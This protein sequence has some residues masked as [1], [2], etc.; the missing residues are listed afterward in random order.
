VSNPPYLAEAE[1]PGLPVEVRDWE[2]EEALVSGP[3]GLE[4]I[5]SVL[6]GAP[7]W[8][9]ARGSVVVEL[10]P[11]QAGAAMALA[12][13]AGLAEVAVHDDLVGRARVLTARAH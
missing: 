8:L 11:H 7:A 2:P 13:S 10:A 9:S 5:A 3:T 12:C 4:A 6:A 1:V